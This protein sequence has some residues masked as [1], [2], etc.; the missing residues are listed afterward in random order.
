MIGY[1]PI[2]DP[3]N[4]Q[5]LAAVQED[6]RHAMVATRTLLDE[7]EEKDAPLV[8]VMAVLSTSLAR[9]PLMTQDRMASLLALAL[10]KAHAT[11][12]ENDSKEFTD[13]IRKITD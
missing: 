13:F 6:F 7:A 5:V 3:H 10:I 12:L 11:T 8:A 2:G 1:V 4:D 9:D